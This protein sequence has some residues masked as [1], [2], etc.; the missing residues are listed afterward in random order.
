MIFVGEVIDK[1]SCIFKIGS[2]NNTYSL[3]VVVT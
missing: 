3:L 1:V 2:T